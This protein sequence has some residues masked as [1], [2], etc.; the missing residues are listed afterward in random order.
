[1]SPSN[2]DLVPRAETLEALVELYLRLNGYFCIRNYLQHRTA[3][4]GLETESDVLALR[5]PHQQEELQNGRVQPNDDWLVLPTTP[6]MTDCVIAEVKEPAVEFNKS[7][8]GSEGARLIAQAL[9]MF[10]VLPDDLF[11]KGGRGWAVCEE[12]HRALNDPDWPAIPAAMVAEEHVTIRMM[13]FA[14]REAHLGSRRAF[15]DLEHVLDFVR[16]RMAPAGASSEYRG[17]E[18]SPWRGTTRL[19]VTALDSAHAAG[20]A[21]YQFPDLIRDVLESWPR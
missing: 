1:M 6:A 17:P 12:L 16:R 15:I 18:F 14:P 21:T 11:K 13:V 9:R 4:F 10:G 20:A 7:M 3:G 5:M 19:I 8:R 2:A